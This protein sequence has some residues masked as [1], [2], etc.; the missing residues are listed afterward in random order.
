MDIS[1]ANQI[2]ESPEKVRVL[3]QG[4]PVWIEAVDEGDQTAWVYP[5]NNPD[6]H[7]KVPVRELE[8]QR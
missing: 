4:V 1:R 8:E 3:H 5:E 2:V 6:D 7:K